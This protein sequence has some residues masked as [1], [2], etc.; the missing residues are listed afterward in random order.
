ML[1]SKILKATAEGLETNREQ[2]K[3]I[4]RELEAAGGFREPTTYRT[5]RAHG[6]TKIGEKTGTVKWQ[7]KIRVLKDGK[8]HLGMAIDA[9]TGQEWPAKLV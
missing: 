3:G 1:E 7:S 5:G 9:A 4:V 8:V 6:V 2:H